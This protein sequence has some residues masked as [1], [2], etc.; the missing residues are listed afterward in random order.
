M[1]KFFILGIIILSSFLGRAQ[2]CDELIKYVKSEGYG[3]TYSSPLSDAIS[4][5]TFYSIVIDYQTHNFAIV[6]FKTS[7]YSYGCSEYIYMVDSY[8]QTNYSL[9]YL[10]SAGKAFWK[11]IQPFHRN[12]SCSP[13]LS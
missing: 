6:C 4:K 10:N 7:A 5:V 12:L 9:N 8:T 3:T 13:D 1:K 2:D 11:Y